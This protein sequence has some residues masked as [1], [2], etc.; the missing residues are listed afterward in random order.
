M[1]KLTSASYASLGDNQ[2]EGAILN[3]DSGVLGGGAFRGTGLS[4]TN[5]P[6]NPQSRRTLEAN[7]SSL[8]SYDA[9]YMNESWLDELGLNLRDKKRRV[10]L[11]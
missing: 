5:L 9:L 4:K 10:S 6:A 8:P 3:D 1:V 7:P 2:G 11:I